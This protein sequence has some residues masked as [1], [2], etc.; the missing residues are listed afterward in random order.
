MEIQAESME[1]FTKPLQHD[2]FEIS[3]QEPINL[4][5]S[6]SAANA[7]ALAFFAMNDYACVSIADPKR[8][9]VSLRDP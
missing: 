9:H 2:E 8:D 4:S 5:V 6:S 1:V 7:G 3:Q